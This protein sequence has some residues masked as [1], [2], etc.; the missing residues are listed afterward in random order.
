MWRHLGM[1]D[2]VG[3]VDFYPNGGGCQSICNYTWKSVAKPFCA[4]AK[5]IGYFLI[6]F[7]N[8]C[9]YISSPCISVDICEEGKSSCTV[10]TDKGNR[11]GYHSYIGKGHQYVDM[12]IYHYR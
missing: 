2:A 9:K 4:R 12:D 11:V 8:S 6:S 5:S 1:T 10:S 7:K 3:H